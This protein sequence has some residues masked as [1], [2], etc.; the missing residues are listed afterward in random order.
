MALDRTD[1]EGDASLRPSRWPPRL[2]GGSTLRWAL[3][4]VLLF[5]A[6]GVVQLG[7]PDCVAREPSG[8]PGSPGPAGPLAGG[9]STGATSAGGP[10]AGRSGSARPPGG[11]A[12]GTGDGQPRRDTTPD[13]REPALP[14]PAG[15]VGVPIRL[16][17]PAALAVTRPGV[18]VDLLAAVPEPG[19]AAAKP[20]LVAGRALVL[21]VLVPEEGALYLALQPEQARRA[22]ALPDTARFSIIVRP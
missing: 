4:A 12:D 14:V 19:R 21:D 20:L 17:E 9:P 11:G 1:T 6:F 2:T 10:S 22:I 15:A 18:R 8:V 16:A 7:A 5:V 13:E 3:A